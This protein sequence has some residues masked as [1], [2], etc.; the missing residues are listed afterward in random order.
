MAHKASQFLQTFLLQSEIL[1]LHG[2]LG[3]GVS[4]SSD[5]SEY[6]CYT[7]EFHTSLFNSVYHYKMYRVTSDKL[8]PKTT[9]NFAGHKVQKSNV[10]KI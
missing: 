5:F 2:P 10:T 8:F 7:R 4:E 1:E 3:V 6:S 9:L